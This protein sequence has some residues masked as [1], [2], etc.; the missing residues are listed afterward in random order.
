[1][2]AASRLGKEPVGERVRF[3]Q[4]VAWLP[5]SRKQIRQLVACEVIVSAQP[6][7]RGAQWYLKTQIKQAL[8]L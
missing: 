7:K 1:M 8:N 4:L 2:K 5:Y 6:G 3:R